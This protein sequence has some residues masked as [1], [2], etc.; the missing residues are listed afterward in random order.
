MNHFHY[1]NNELYAED[2]AL[3]NIVTQVGSPV[4]VYSHATLSP[5]WFLCCSATRQ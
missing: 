1:R 5:A 4:Y 2:V 3:K